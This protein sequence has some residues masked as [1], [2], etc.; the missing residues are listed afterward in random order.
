PKSPKINSELINRIKPSSN[1][2]AALKDLLNAMISK[3][4]QPR[5]GIEGYPAEGGLFETLLASSGLYVKTDEGFIFRLPDARHDAA[6]LGPLWKAAD[7]FFK[8]NHN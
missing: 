6:R 8:K 3:Q 7:Q 5:L 4:G 2:V 1:S